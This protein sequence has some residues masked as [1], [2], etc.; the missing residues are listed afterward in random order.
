MKWR[1]LKGWM[2]ASMVCAWVVVGCS[3]DP[4]PLEGSR[5]VEETE[6]F[7]L[8]D[9]TG[10]S[11]ALQIGDVASI[12]VVL[13]DANRG[14]GAVGEEVEFRLESG[15]TDGQLTARGVT[16]DEQGRAEVGLRAG[17]EPGTLTVVATHPLA[18]PLRLSVT[19]VAAPTGALGIEL[20]HGAASIM[21]LTEIE[22]RLHTEQTLTCAEFRPYGTSGPA[23][24]A[25]RVSRL[26]SPGRTA[27]FEGLPVDESLVA[28][29]VAR[30]D[31]GQIAAAGCLEG[32]SVTARSLTRR[33][34]VLTLL[35]LDVDGIYATTS[36]WDFSAAVEESGAVGEQLL[37]VL[38]VFHAPGRAL[39]EEIVSLVTYLVGGVVG[40]SLDFF[41]EQTGLDR[42]FQMLIDRAIQNNGAMC[43]VREAGRDLRDVI[44][45]LTVHS[46]TS[47][48]GGASGTAL[49]GRQHW[50]GLSLYWRGLCDA[51]YLESCQPGGDGAPPEQRKRPCAEIPFVADASGRIAGFGLLSTEWTGRLTAY[52]RLEIRQ[53]DVPLRYGRLITLL[54]NET[55]LPALTDGHAHSL[56]EAFGYWLKCD[57]LA[58]SV[59]GADGRVCALG[60]CL[61]TEDLAKSCESAI[62]GLFGTADLML[63][64]LAWQT[65]VS[66]GGHATAIEVDSDGRVDLL[67]EGTWS[68]R[69]DV[70]RS[71]QRGE[72]AAVHGRWMGERVSE[73]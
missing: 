26:D 21:P 29:A 12:A 46:E 63:E 27:R 14:R 39:Y 10:G 67:E 19:V 24:A 40:G 48:A 9:A 58:R 5:S 66:V 55:I 57:G 16:T 35:P 37:R 69:I 54:L 28:V 30:G 59:T 33:E 17:L 4:L 34:L 49:R 64:Q 36:H 18:R 3:G 31:R 44:A 1:R 70:T 41:F 32:L 2:L 6:R 38:N 8:V 45:Q 50:L 72:A 68:G 56:A 71:G 73:R 62:A 53:H 11:P 20:T 60:R 52:D 42:E 25:L 51:G 47:V 43:R 65:G 7:W 15:S 22:V 13:V 61:Y 23:P